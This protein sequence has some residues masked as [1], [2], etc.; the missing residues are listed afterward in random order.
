MKPNEG[1][2]QSSEHI[3]AKILE[4]RLNDIVVGISKFKED[5]GL[6]EITSKTDPRGLSLNEIES[7]VNN[8]IKK[9]L[10]VHKS[11]LKRE[12]AEKEVD[13]GKVPSSVKEVT[14]I[15][16]EGFDKRPCRDPHVD[17]TKEIGHFKILDFDK[18]G[19]GRY[20]FTFRV[21]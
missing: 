18:V 10:P 3:L 2:L 11:I 5:S 17:N 7:E 21:E 1:R 9:E 15:D 20:R 4:D 19:N 6:L 14:I 16:I 8:V 12:E 13:L